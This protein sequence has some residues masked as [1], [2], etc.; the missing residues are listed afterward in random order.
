M[1]K[2]LTTEIDV[3]RRGEGKSRKDSILN[4]NMRNIMNPWHNIITTTKNILKQFGH[5]KIR[6]NRIPIMYLIQSY[7]M[8]SMDLA[9]LSYAKPFAEV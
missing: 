8:D 7:Q 3:Y 1:N 6:S 5:L 4:L 2:L 9:E